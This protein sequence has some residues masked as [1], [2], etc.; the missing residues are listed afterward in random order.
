MS[1]FLSIVLVGFIPAWS[2]AA[3]LELEGPW[4]FRTDPGDVGTN[5]G[6]ATAEKNDSNWR[7][8]EI[9][10]PWEEL[11]YP[12]YDGYAWYRCDVDVPAGFN[13]K[14]TFIS[15]AGV[16]DAYQ[17]FID[18]VL[19]GGNGDMVGKSKTMNWIPSFV[20]I[21]SVLKVG[22]K[23]QIAFRVHDFGGGGGIMPADVKLCDDTKLLPEA[24]RY[25][26]AADKAPAGAYPRWVEQKQVYWTI[27][28]VEDAD[29]ESALGEE[30]TIE[31]KSKKF[32]IAPFLQV[33][34]K[35]LTS[36]DVDLSQTLDDGY[37]PIPT[38][39]WKTAN[40][41]LRQMLFTWGPKDNAVTYAVYEL[42][43]TTKKP[44]SGKLFLTFRPFQLVPP[45]MYG[46]MADI[47]KIDFLDNTGQQILI[48]DEQ[49]IVATSKP[50][51]YGAQSFEND[52]VIEVLLKGE[53]PQEKNADDQTGGVSGAIAYDFNLEP[54]QNVMYVFTMPLD[55]RTGEMKIPTE[56]Q[57]ASELERTRGYWRDRL[58]RVVLACP[59]KVLMDTFR[60]NLAYVLITRDRSALQ[61]GCRNYEKAWIRD[62]A[63]M[64]AAMLRVGC[65]KE[66]KTFLDW[67]AA[68]QLSNGEMPC[69]VQADGNRPGFSL[70]WK[71]YDGQ[72]AFVFG[73]AEY[74]RFTRDKQFVKKQ[75]PVIKKCLEFL[76]HLRE[77]G[78]ADKEEAHKGILPE[79]ISHEGY[80]PPMHSYWDDFWALRGWKDGQLLAEIA[81]QHEQL[82]WMKREE[83]LLRVGTLR[84]ID[85]V[86]SRGKAAYI[87][88][89]AEKCDF[90]ATST[91]ISVWPTDEYRNLPQEALAATFNRYY[92]DTLLPR[93]KEF[94]GDGFTPYEVRTGLAWLIRGEVDK[95]WVLLDHLLNMRRP[96]P[97]NHWAEVVTA[98]RNKPQYLGDMPHM[99]IGSE[100]M[101][102]VRSL[103]LYEHDNRLILGRGIRKEWL[104]QDTPAEVKNAP[105]HFGAISY[106][107]K[108]SGDKMVFRAEGD[109]N[110]PAGFVLDLCGKQIKFDELPMEIKLG[111]HVGVNKP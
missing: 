102:V 12:D 14:D 43:N 7:S 1:R 78:L 5:Q 10:K 25:R 9:G 57:V 54:K 106:S 61:P 23:V 11:G 74:Y 8:I 51:A 83:E 13:P 92:N 26:L 84:S 100:F 44:A 101:V 110:P 53:M 4:W 72:G 80:F 33:D 82:D 105:T 35:F 39:E 45:T 59:D 37:L 60:A 17:V 70:D 28:G 81:G 96:E 6:W 36:E 31:L 16:D 48:N 56:L 34:G 73:C 98:D 95:T 41:S 99:W 15:V 20:P 46:G 94:A 71:E 21:G 2:Q 108:R 19:A 52:D 90:D 75:Y 87:P 62:G 67:F 77:Q 55:K 42:S 63:E 107:L 111:I 49:L 86:R 97:W 65:D 85:L 103:F 29:F 64:S 30:G 104:T 88:G 79:S 24:D 58:N 3:T 89:C 22:K 76:Q 66:A 18:G 50:D 38:V 32:S 68:Q 40:L 27:T 93:I 69:I 109:A 91:A 47:R